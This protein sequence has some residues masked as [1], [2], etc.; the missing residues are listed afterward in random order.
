MKKISMICNVIGAIL[1]L[2]LIPTCIVDYTHYNS[3]LNSAPF[4]VWILTDALCLIVPAVVLFVVG[5]I[6][7]KKQ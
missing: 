6:L 5:W 7:K 1:L 3:T 4:Y 2:S